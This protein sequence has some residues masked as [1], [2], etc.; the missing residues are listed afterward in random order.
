MDLSSQLSILPMYCEQGTYLN[1]RR[2]FLFLSSLALKASS[3]EAKEQGD[4]FGV[5]VQKLSAPMANEVN[6][7]LG[8]EKIFRVARPDWHYLSNEEIELAKLGASVPQKAK[9]S[10]GSKTSR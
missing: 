3:G 1:A 5:L 6:R 7:V 2:M 8:V 9:A 10:F 4:D